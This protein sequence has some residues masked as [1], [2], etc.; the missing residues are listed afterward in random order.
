MKINLPKIFLTTRFLF[1]FALVMMSMPLL[2]QQISSQ[3]ALEKARKF[4]ET[5]GKTIAQRARSAMSTAADSP[6][7]YYIF[8]ADKKQGYVIVS[9]DERTPEILGYS[10]NG[11]FDETAMPQNMRSWLQ[12]YADEIAI[13]QKH[14]MTVPRR[15]V[16]NCGPAIA[17]QLTCLW[18]QGEPFN[19]DCPMVTAYSDETCTEVKQTAERSITGC[20]AT[21]LAQVLYMWKDEYQNPS[22]KE[23]KLTKAIPSRANFKWNDEY[24]NAWL[25]FSDDEIPAETT[26]D[27]GNL[28]DDYRAGQGTDAQKAAV[29]QLMHICGAAMDMNYGLEDANYSGSA[30][31]AGGGAT[32]AYEY[33][34]FKNI[35]IYHQ[36]AYSYQEWLN[37]LYNELKVAKVVN[38]G[39]QST[40][41]GHAF[42]IDG[43]DKEDLFHVNWGW[44]GLANEATDNGGFY[45][46]NSLLPSD[47][48]YG[49][50]LYNDG[51]KTSQSFVTGLYPKAAAN[52][53]ELQ[54]T[55]FSVKKST[56][57]L[58]GSDNFQVPLNF[59]VYNYSSLAPFN[60]QLVFVFEKS[61]NTKV[62]FNVS[63]FSNLEQY[64]GWGRDNDYSDIS[65][66]KGLLSAGE[67]YKLYPAYRLVEGGPYYPCVN[68][69]TNMVSVSVTRNGAALKVQNI[70]PCIL[71]LKSKDSKD[72][73]AVSDAVE[74]ELRIKVDEGEL[75]DNLSII[76]KPITSLNK[77]DNDRLM[78]VSDANEFVYGEKDTEFDLLCTFSNAKWEEGKYQIVLIDTY[79]RISQDLFT[80]NLVK[81][82]GIS[83]V[84]TS[85][86][87]D[88][89]RYFDLQGREVDG[90]TKG[91]IIRRQGDEVK[92]VIVR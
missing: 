72:E 80:I 30:A 17:K 60:A 89:Y 83:I 77:A 33:L 41:G 37:R 36:G 13:I 71:S 12:H 11:S 8:N 67:Q 78:I 40:G 44:S 1:L 74:F 81:P 6:S 21:A 75:H 19:N 43:Y 73:Y 88:G 70:T 45:R 42:V 54:V 50:S 76:A 28:I 35:C 68:Y 85:P 18:D 24:A 65:I 16:A 26:I 91:L 25:Q 56:V 20:A 15:S 82:T 84:K 49:G 32:A 59:G 27:W 57:S 23:G 29:A 5:K 39:G 47:Q 64:Y 58:D 14:N 4:M 62:D 51:F 63:G 3:S 7:P 48:G 52:P 9:G 66:P 92:K 69:D 79:E 53:K 86:S 38:F 61:D 55:R 90:S 22:V 2:A 31:F 87:Y 34:G 46:I 10:E